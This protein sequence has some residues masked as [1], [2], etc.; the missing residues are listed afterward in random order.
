M[1]NITLRTTDFTIDCVKCAIAGHF[2]LSAGDNK[3]PFHSFKTPADVLQRANG[4]HFDFNDVWV[5][6]T[7]DNL[8][9]TFEFEVALKASNTT[10]QFEVPLYSRTKSLIV[11]FVLFRSVII[12]LLE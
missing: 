1:I 7:V 4:S 2:S 9:A 10:N 12:N 11:R 3:I 8:N 6:A 5:A